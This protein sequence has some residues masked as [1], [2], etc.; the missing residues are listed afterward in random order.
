MLLILFWGNSSSA[1]SALHAQDSVLGWGL[2]ARFEACLEASIV[3]LLCPPVRTT[4][5]CVV[6]SFPLAIPAFCQ[7]GNFLFGVGE[8]G[9]KVN[10][11]KGQWWGKL[12][13]AAKS[14][15]WT[16]GSKSSRAQHPGL[17]LTWSVLS[18][19]CWILRGWCYQVTSWVTAAPGPQSSLE[20]LAQ[21]PAP[22][23]R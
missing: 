20:T 10:L 8:C 12:E 21:N 9:P 23:T 2:T 5:H 16:L 3:S 4:W 13:E 15:E 1:C 17:C 19:S 14:K 11:R 6:L 22:H 7:H 18:K